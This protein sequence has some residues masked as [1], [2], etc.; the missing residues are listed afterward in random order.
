MYV[1]TYVLIADSGYM[2]Q[3]VTYIRTT[4][5][6]PSPLTSD[7]YKNEVEEVVCTRV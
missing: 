4:S 7:M 2:K 5:N 3:V 6:V 1:H